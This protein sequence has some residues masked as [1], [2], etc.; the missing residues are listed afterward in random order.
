VAHVTRLTSW[1]NT[2]VK[3]PQLIN[4]GQLPVQPV[5]LWPV[6]TRLWCRPG[7]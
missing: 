6:R 5:E 2:S 7:S 3:I 1:E 4:G